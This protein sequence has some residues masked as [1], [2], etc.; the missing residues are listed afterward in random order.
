V[1]ADE[2]GENIPEQ[3]REEMVNLFAKTHDRAVSFE[4]FYE[5]MQM[6]NGPKVE[7]H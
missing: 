6:A 2:L 3:E 4:E 1:V 7:A 5:I